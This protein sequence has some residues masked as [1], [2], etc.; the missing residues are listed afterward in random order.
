MTPNNGYERLPTGEIMETKTLGANLSFS[1]YIYCISYNN[2]KKSSILALK[3]QTIIS[4]SAFKFHVHVVFV[5]EQ[6]SKP[7]F[8]QMI[9]TFVKQTFWSND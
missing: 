8:G 6:V 5:P 9:D 2:E 1:D 3:F 4:V 7:Y